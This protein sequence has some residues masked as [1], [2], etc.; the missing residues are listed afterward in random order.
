MNHLLL[1]WRHL[2]LLLLLAA[3]CALAQTPSA[4]WKQELLQWRGQRAASLTTPEGWLSLAGL[5]WI[6]PGDNSFG[7]AADNSIVLPGDA[8]AHLG[9]LHL[10]DTLVTLG[11][12]PHGFP[13]GLMVNVQ[14]AVGGILSTSDDQPTRLTIGSLVLY[15]I[16]RGDRYYLRVKDALAPTLINFSGLQWYPPDRRY[17]IQAKWT[18]YNPPQTSTIVDVLGV[19]MQ[20]VVPGVAEFTLDGRQLQL[21]PL[22][23]QPGD[24]HLFFLFRDRTSRT[25]TY[26]A[27]RFLYSDL[28]D[29]GLSQPGT[30][31]LDF[32]RAVNPPCA[33]TAYATCPLPPPQNRLPVAIPAGEKRYHE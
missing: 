21:E 26:G 27:G 16:Q 29:H 23:E 22:L 14:T 3:P 10:S 4:D 6:K 1:R 8:P 24:K 19:S 25:T 13:A 31:T 5:E 11:P 18:P 32:N 17:R 15:V 12:P 28:P 33:Y 2:L 30:I 7:S 20:A 9:I